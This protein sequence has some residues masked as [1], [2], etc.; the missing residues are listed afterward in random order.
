M[1]KIGI[2]AKGGEVDKRSILDT[3]SPKAAPAGRIPIGDSGFYKTPDVI[4]PRDCENYPDSLWCGGNPFSKRLVG[5]D[6]DVDIHSCG[7]DLNIRGTLGIK[8]PTHGVSWRKP[9]ECR[10][11]PPVPPPPDFGDDFPKPEDKPAT[12]TGFDRGINPN[13]EVWAGLSTY[14]MVEN[15]LVVN[16]KSGATGWIPGSLYSVGN[17]LQWDYANAEYFVSTTKYKSKVR[18]SGQIISKTVERIHD[19]PDGRV[20]GGVITEEVPFNQHWNGNDLSTQRFL[21]GS[22][23][24]LYQIYQ[25]GTLKFEDTTVPGPYEGFSGYFPKGSAPESILVKGRWGLIQQY[26]C[27]QAP[28]PPDSH[29]YSKV[30]C[31]GVLMADEEGKNPHRENPGPPPPKKRECC[32]QCCS[33]ASQN[34]NNQDLKEVLAILRRLDKNVGVFPTKVTIFDS[35]ETKEEAQAK[36]LDIASISQGI[37]RIIEQQQKISKII[38]IDTFPL[39]LPETLIETV[40]DNIIEMVWD[41]ITPDKTIK[42][43]N[44]MSLLVYILKYQNAVFGQWMQKI[45]IQDQD[46]TKEGDQSKDIVIPDMANAIRELLTVSMGI[47]KALGLCTDVS[48]K[49]LAESATIKQEVV[50]ALLTVKDIQQWL[51]Y[52]TDERH[53]KVPIQITVPEIKN[54]EITGNESDEE[55]IL[56]EQQQKQQQAQENDLEKFLKP[57]TTTITY[58]DWDGKKSFTDYILHL[59]TLIASSRGQR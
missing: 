30:H 4:D 42:I 13:A 36:V 2:T 9:G 27:S 16:S 44:V 15:N 29:Y 57:S 21:I 41:W 10:N 40:D 34:N 8:L 19:D 31:F 53:L 11:Q 56:K 45:H 49:T 39:E 37:V 32:M 54:I 33:P 50:K 1:V 25:Y 17:Y 14:V 46:A 48:V 51:D 47:Y 43:N 55:R 23:G 6:V 24:R 58:D 3:L 5:I 52:T 26:Y 38:G 7:G 12:P 35:D 59:G 18:V 22:D 28:F 20:W